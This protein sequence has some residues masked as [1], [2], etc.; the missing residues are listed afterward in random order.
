MRI[1]LVNAT[2]IQSAE[3][4]G[5]PSATDEA[6]SSGMREPLDVRCTA[7]FD[8][9]RS[10]FGWF[11]VLSRCRCR[12]QA[13]GGYAIHVQLVRNGQVKINAVVFRI[14]GSDICED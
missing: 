13:E 8:G 4:V 5:R 11:H 14:S 9:R 2:A 12:G 7:D 6:Q 1:I 10:T 3:Q